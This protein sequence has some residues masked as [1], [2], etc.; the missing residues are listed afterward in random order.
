MTPRRVA[1]RLSINRWPHPQTQD[2]APLYGMEHLGGLVRFVVRYNVMDVVFGILYA[3]SN[4]AEDELVSEYFGR[5]AVSYLASRMCNVEPVSYSH[6]ILEL[7]PDT[8]GEW[9]TSAVTNAECRW[10]HD[11]SRG[12]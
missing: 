12:W 9:W 3:V 10:K 2:A 8:A 11:Y 5:V 6:R 1:L 4:D 7:M